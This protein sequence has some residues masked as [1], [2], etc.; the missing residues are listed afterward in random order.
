MGRKDRN[1]AVAQVSLV[2]EKNLF[3]A[4]NLEFHEVMWNYQMPQA[5]FFFHN[6]DVPVVLLRSSSQPLH[7]IMIGFYANHLSC[8]VEEIQQ[9]GL[10]LTC[11]TIQNRLSRE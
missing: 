7:G 4:W 2:I 5:E 1:N 8:P 11:T 9:C 10:P 6:L 3:T